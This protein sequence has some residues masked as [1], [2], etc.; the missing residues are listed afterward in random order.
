MKLKCTR[1]GEIFSEMEISNG[2][3]NCP[4]EDEFY[5]VS[6]CKICGKEC[7][8]ISM[9]VCED[10]EEKLYSNASLMKLFVK[11]GDPNDFYD[12]L[13]A[14]WL[15]KNGIKCDNSI[16]TCTARGYSR[17]NNYIEMPKVD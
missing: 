1:C 14:K 16:L 15:R 7:E 5:E 17:V 4:N 2:C 3:P 12:W 9:K 11:S 13:D 6:V 8:D 10:C